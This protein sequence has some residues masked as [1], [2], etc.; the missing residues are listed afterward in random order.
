[1]FLLP[2]PIWCRGRTALSISLSSPQYIT[3]HSSYRSTRY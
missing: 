2:L 3:P 1:M